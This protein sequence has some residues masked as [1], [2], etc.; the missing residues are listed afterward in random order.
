M[1]R[2]VQGGSTPP[3]RPSNIPASGTPAAARGT[4]AAGRIGQRATGPLEAAPALSAQPIARDVIAAA[5]DAVMSRHDQDAPAILGALSEQDALH[6]V[7]HLY[8]LHHQAPHTLNPR[9]VEAASRAAAEP[10]AANALAGSLAAL[11]TAEDGPVLP[12]P[13]G[14]AAAVPLAARTAPPGRGGAVFI[15]NRATGNGWPE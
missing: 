3:D 11:V 2:P 6:V 13:R 1:V 15:S 7:E 12:G 14:G 10:D 5:L 8:Q 9:V 4:P